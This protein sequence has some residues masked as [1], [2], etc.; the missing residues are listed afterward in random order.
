MRHPVDRDLSGGQRFLPFEQL[1]PG[2]FHTI[3]TNC[4][5]QWI[6]IYPEDSAI[7]LL[8]NWGQ[9]DFTHSSRLFDY[10]RAEREV[11]DDSLDVNCK[12]R[13]IIGYTRSLH[14]EMKY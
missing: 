7:Y 1:G 8:N 3:S 11:I 9:E 10:A 6:E 12:N 5:I 13:P 14:T 4:A 2:G